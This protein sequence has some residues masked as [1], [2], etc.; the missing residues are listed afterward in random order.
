MKVLTMTSQAVRVLMPT[1]LTLIAICVT[2]QGASFKVNRDKL[3]ESYATRIGAPNRCVAW[4]SMTPS[5]KGVFLTITDLLGKRSFMT[6][7]S[8]R[9]YKNGSDN[10][11][12]S[13]DPPGTDCTSGCYVNEFRQ[14]GGPCFYMTGEECWQKGFCT[15][16]EAPRSDFRT[17]LDYVTRIWAI[18]GAGGG[19]G[20]GNSNRLYFTAS[21]ELMTLIRNFEFGLPEW[22]DS[23]DLAGPHSPF[24][25]SSETFTGQP[26]GQIHFWRWDHEAQVLFRPGVE[27]VYDP[28]I[29]EIDLDYNTVHDSNPL[30]YYDGLYGLIKYQNLWSPRGLGGSAEF[31][32]NPCA[33]AGEATTVSAASFLGSKL[34]IGSLAAGFGNGLAATTESAPDGRFPPTTL[35]DATVTVVD[36]SGVSHSAGIIYASLTQINHTIPVSAAHG[37]A[38]IIYHNSV[39]GVS[40]TSTGDLASVACGLFSRNG[41]GAG[42]ANAVILRKRNGMDFYEPVSDIVNGQVVPVP[43]DFGPETDQLIL[44]LFGTGFRFRSSLSNMKVTVGGIPLEP[45]YAGSAGNALPY[46]DQAN[47]QLTRSLAGSGLVGVVMT[48]DG[49]TSNTVQVAFGHP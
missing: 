1:I 25:N 45:I 4:N 17:A 5:Q 7:R 38:K 33:A 14:T 30:C 10:I 15:L 21:D 35:G 9:F 32:Y 43:I 44:V 3:L 47:V 22:R 28:H 37:P 20:G 2:G 12:G 26:R 39:T 8:F 29:V 11:D 46:M 41:T 18:N 13:C 49:S 6:N 19:C 24:N 16:E 40:F 42:I 48:A 31:D 36:S 23:A 34:A 27:G